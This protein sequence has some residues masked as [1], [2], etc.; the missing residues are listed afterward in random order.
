MREAPNN[1]RRFSLF[2]PPFI[3][4]QQPL[5]IKNWIAWKIWKY[6][7]YKNMKIWKICKYE[8]YEKSEEKKILWADCLV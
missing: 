7:K 2:Q 6:E 3:L 5:L 4:P 1:F 8:K